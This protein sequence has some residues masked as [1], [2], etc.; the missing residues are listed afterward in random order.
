MD[1]ARSWAQ[2]Q[3]G[4]AELGDLRRTR[5]LV[6]LAAEVVKRPSGIVSR[7]CA[8][9]ASREGAFRLLE[10]PR[11]RADNILEAVFEKT[12]KDCRGKGT[13]IVPVDAS[14]LSFEDDGRKGLG[15][16]AHGRWATLERAPIRAK[17]T[18]D[19]AA[20]ASPTKKRRRTESPPSRTDHLEEHESRRS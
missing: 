4:H 13:V 15:R 7:A 2:E 12:A 1:D 6:Q 19:V 14:S 3:F 8:T 10:S 5:R 16:I 11:V 18:I 9:S 20:G 17:K